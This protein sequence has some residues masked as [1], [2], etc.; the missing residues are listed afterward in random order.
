MRGAM[1]VRGRGRGRRLPA[2]GAIDPLPAPLKRHRLSADT[3]Q[4]LGQLGVLDPELRI[5]LVDG[6]IIEMAPLGSRH[7]AMVNRLDERLRQAIGQRAIV[8]TQSSFRLDEHSEPEPDIGV[9]ERREDFYALALPTAAQTLLL[10]EVSD[11]S[12]RYD[13]DI[14]LPLY[15]RNGVPEV[16]IVDLESGLLRIHRDPRG[17]DYLHTR[18]TPAPGQVDMVAL[19]GV[20]VDLSAL[21]D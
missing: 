11:T 4:R 15:A 13:R 19:P 21:F 20:T 14:K 10:V 17:D 1:L 2:M 18:A 8:S 7:W 3:Y 5:E 9:F 6:E 12:V 16:W